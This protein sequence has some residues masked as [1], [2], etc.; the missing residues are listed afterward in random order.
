MNVTFHDF[1]RHPS[2]WQDADMAWNSVKPPESRVAL[3][4]IGF[5][6]ILNTIMVLS[7]CF[8]C[9]GVTFISENYM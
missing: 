4:S 7:R 9:R 2:Y 6:A 3:I 5:F 8:V 1:L